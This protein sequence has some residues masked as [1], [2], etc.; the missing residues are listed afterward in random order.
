M[1]S[2][3][4]QFSG[5]LRFLKFFL[6]SADF[7]SRKHLSFAGGDGVVQVAVANEAPLDSTK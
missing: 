3:A 1:Q 5:F 7:L 4:L 2:C 6:L